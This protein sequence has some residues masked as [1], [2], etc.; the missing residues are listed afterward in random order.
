MLETALDDARR[1]TKS[2]RQV[3]RELHVNPDTI[4]A[5][6]KRFGIDIPALLRSLPVRSEPLVTPVRESP[7]VIEHLGVTTPVD[8]TPSPEKNILRLTAADFSGPFRGDVSGLGR[9][10]RQ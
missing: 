5:S 10:R 1:C 8:L 4:Y 9:R 6:A 2:I 7:Q 3:A